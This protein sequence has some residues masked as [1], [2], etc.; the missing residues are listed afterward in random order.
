[1]RLIA[2][3]LLVL[4]AAPAARAACTV[5]PDAAAVG[6]AMLAGVNAQRAG[7]GRGALA[8]DPRLTQAAQLHACDMAARRKLD[9][10]G[11]DGSSH[12]TR[13]KRAGCRYRATLSE[14]IGYGFGSVG[15]ML[16]AW[17]GSAG[18]RK[19]ILERKNRVAGV[20]YA[21]GPGGPWWVMMY[22]GGC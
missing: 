4:L 5:P 16:G 18:H 10:K 7:N 1:M 21:T 9:H 2:A 20:G 14:N 12:V 22:A 6:A 11:S 15:R 19:N 8:M 17:M 13:A 3:L